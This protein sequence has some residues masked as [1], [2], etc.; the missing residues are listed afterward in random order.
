MS[1]RS[2]KA[3][4]QIISDFASNTTIHGIRYVFDVT[5]LIIERLVWLIICISLTFLAIYWSMEIFDHWKENPV[6]TS[7]KTTGN[8][9]NNSK[10]LIIFVKFPM[11]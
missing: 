6:L 11:L 10:Y 2:K 4:K 5:A 8:Y 9:A 7:V 3:G 1:S